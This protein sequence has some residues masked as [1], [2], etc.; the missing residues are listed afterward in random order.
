MI[1]FTSPQDKATHVSHVDRPQLPMS[2]GDAA[3]AL[4]HCLAQR[5]GKFQPADRPGGQLVH[6]TQHGAEQNKESVRQGWLYLSSRALTN[7]VQVPDSAS[8][9]STPKEHKICRA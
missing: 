5:H 8:K 9:V 1:A 3:H 6:H 2:N 4:M 7:R